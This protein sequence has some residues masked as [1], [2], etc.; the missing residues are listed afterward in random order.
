M[1]IHIKVE[2]HHINGG[3]KYSPK[4]CPIALAVREAT[5]CPR[6]WVVFI[7]PSDCWIRG[8][9]FHIPEFALQFMKDFDKG[10][11]VS[12]IEFYIPLSSTITGEYPDETIG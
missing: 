6:E 12:P 3:F 4:Q 9:S 8:E 2:N 7:S 5:R 10:Y 1:L 11:P